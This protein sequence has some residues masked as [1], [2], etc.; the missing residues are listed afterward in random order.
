VISRLKQWKN[1]PERRRVEPNL[2]VPFYSN[3]YN[4]FFTISAHLSVVKR[5]YGTRGEKFFHHRLHEKQ[6]LDMS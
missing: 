3:V 6:I 2:E 4:L 1:I 5:I